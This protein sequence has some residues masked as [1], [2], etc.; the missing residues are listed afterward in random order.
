[1]IKTLSRQKEGRDTEI[2]TKE[3]K[4]LAHKNSGGNSITNRLGKEHPR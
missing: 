1:M 2:F 4:P 3:K